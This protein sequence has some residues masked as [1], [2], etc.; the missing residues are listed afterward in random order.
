M[1]L[2]NKFEWISLFEEWRSS[3]LS[4][5]EFC[6]QRELNYRTVLYALKRLSPPDRL[7]KPKPLKKIQAPAFL[8]LQTEKPLPSREWIE[9]VLPHG[10]ILRIPA[11]A[12]A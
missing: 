12:P 10:I 11:H 1:K 6:N 2:K 4:K 3:G 8:K 9:I 7:A 5:T